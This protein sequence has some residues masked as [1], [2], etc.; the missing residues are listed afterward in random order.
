MNKL[1]VVVA[2]ACLAGHTT[3]A[4]IKPSG[5]ADFKGLD[6]YLVDKMGHVE[7]SQSNLRQL[8]AGVDQ[9]EGGVK[10]A[11]EVFIE[12][13]DASQCDD[14]LLAVL[15]EGASNGIRRM[16][17]SQAWNVIVP[18]LARLS[19]LCTDYIDQTVEQRFSAA[20]EALKRLTETVRP[21]GV[22]NTTPDVIDHSENYYFLMND[23]FG[24][25]SLPKSHPDDEYETIN[26]EKL[27]LFLSKLADV[28]GTPKDVELT[29]QKQLL[30]PCERYES[31]FGDLFEGAKL[32]SRL[33]GDI[34]T[35]AKNRSTRFRC[36]AY[37]H[38]VCEA[39]KI[40]NEQE[41]G[42]NALK[43]SKRDVLV[44]SAPR[45]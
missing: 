23:Q 42:N 16:S 8:R 3:G 41:D 1:L 29:F 36:L 32:M 20:D 17:N 30:E 28:A 40:V 18:H 25:N 4:S 22:D 14:H 24:P 12:L 9:L 34:P 44:A 43:C 35:Y 21:T 2:V 13:S 45:A 26:A 33:S 27:G 6:E 37:T 7:D 10:R 5:Q 38:K 19:N 15:R 31:T 11:A 39:V